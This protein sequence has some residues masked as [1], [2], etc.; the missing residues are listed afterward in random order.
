MGSGLQGQTLDD[1]AELARAGQL[2]VNVHTVA[3]TPGLVRG[4]LQLEEEGET[5]F[6]FAAECSGLNQVTNGSIVPIDTPTTANFTLT[7]DRLTSTA[8]WSLRVSD[9]SQMLMSHIHAGNETSNGPVAVLL[10]PGVPFGPAP[11]SPSVAPS[12]A[13]APE[14]APAPPPPGGAASAAKACSRL[15]CALV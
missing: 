5:M 15:C 8:E 7:V 12:P 3:D 13:P 10:A 9:V 2:Y 1:M 4:Q 14:P 11:P 6:V